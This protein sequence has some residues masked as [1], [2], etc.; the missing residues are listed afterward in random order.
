MQDKT[1]SAIIAPSVSAGG[2]FPVRIP[3][4]MTPEERARIGQTACALNR[5]I[6]RYLVELATSEVNT[7]PNPFSVRTYAVVGSNKVGFVRY[8]RIASRTTCFLH[9]YQLSP[10]CHR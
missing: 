8:A 1:P 2:R 3:I 5:S 4:R 7:R 10:V 9:S 6:S